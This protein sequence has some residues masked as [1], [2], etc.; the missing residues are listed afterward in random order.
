VRPGRSTLATALLGLLLV[1]ACS[2]E[3]AGSP[4]AS[5]GSTATGT[6]FPVTLTDDDGVEITII[7]E[8]ERIVTFAPSMTEIVFALGLGDR[9]VGVSGPSDDFPAEARAIPSVGAGEFGVE[10]NLET[11][12]ALEPDLFLTIAGGDEW[13]EQLRDL[14][15]PVATFNATDLDDLLND[16]GSVGA[17]TGVAD[18][19]DALV[20]DMAAEAEEIAGTVAER[21]TCF[22]EVYF[23]KTLTTVGPKTF[24]YDLL[25]RAGCDPVTADATS[26]YPAW[27]VED[28]VAD[29]P[30][31]YLVTVESA[32]SI[33]QIAE[34]PGFSG[35]PAV[36]NGDVA[37]V[38]PDLVTRP[39]PRVV[40]GLAQI[41]A[42]LSEAGG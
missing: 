19:A 9:V 30:A 28:L 10:P 21:T 23:A 11:V 39:G 5:S 33:E 22:F 16:I 8:P 32:T 4:S 17:L 26:D 41:A 40:E 7:Q 13:K 36:A 24:I 18:R 27:S 3:E 25:Q 37:F 38:D 31:V 34:R 29:P 35:I 42:A 14:G 15:V 6:A 12:V 2:A 20:A 1:S